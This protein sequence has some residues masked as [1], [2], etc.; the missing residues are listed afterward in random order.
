MVQTR[1][2]EYQTPVPIPQPFVSAPTS[3]QMSEHEDFNSGEEDEAQPPQV[4]LPLPRDASK[5][6]T[7]K[8]DETDAQQLDTFLVA[9]RRYFRVNQSSYAVDPEDKLKVASFAQCFPLSSLARLWYDGV[10]ETLSSYEIFEEEL[11]A[12]F[13]AGE[14]NLIKLQQQ[15][16]QARQSRFSARDFYHH[17]QKL[18]MRIT[19]VAADEKPNDREFLRKFCSNLREPV[20]TAIQKRRIIEPDL[21]LPQLVKLAE[22]EDKPVSGSATPALRG[23]N[24]F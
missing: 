15:W 17:L 20:K 6:P 7:F 14:A 24:S 8:G 21:T 22:L 2:G 10:E 3:P 4:N 5:L 1:H 12:N 11:R 9:L 16:E 13:A 18:R 23:A 19:A